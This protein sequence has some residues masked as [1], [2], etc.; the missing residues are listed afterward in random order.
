MYI[1][2]S[3]QPILTLVHIK[4]DHEAEMFRKVRACSWFKGDT[5]AACWLNIARAS[6]G[7]CP[8]GGRFGL[9]LVDVYGSI[10]AWRCFQDFQGYGSLSHT[11]TN[12]LHFQKMIYLL[13]IYQK[14]LRLEYQ[15][16]IEKRLA[17]WFGSRWFWSEICE[18]RPS[19][20]SVL[21]AQKKLPKDEDGELTSGNQVSFISYLSACLSGGNAGKQDSKR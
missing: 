10:Q 9:P 7:C 3:C 14:N 11:K 5:C 18:E 19:M 6:P 13:S 17:Y 20:A 2:K 16:K 8:E 15:Q 21:E 1:T 4:L 12:P